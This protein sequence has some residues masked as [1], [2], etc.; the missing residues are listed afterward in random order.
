MSEYPYRWVASEQTLV[1]PVGED[2]YLVQKIG[3]TTQAL[4]ETA[5]VVSVKD[6]DILLNGVLYDLGDDAMSFL[7]LVDEAD[8][9]SQV[10]QTYLSDP[11]TYQG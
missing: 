8:S 6:G 9:V 3:V 10:G 1:T 11:T 2:R 4:P 5:V 7:S